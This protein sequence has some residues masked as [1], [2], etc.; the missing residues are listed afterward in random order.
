[1]KKTLVTL[2]IT[3]AL[4]IMVLSIVCCQPSTVHTTATT[5]HTTA[6]TISG[7]NSTAE[8]VIE[9]TM[10]WIYSTTHNKPHEVHDET[11]S[12][13]GLCQLWIYCVDK[14]TGKEIGWRVHLFEKGSEYYLTAPSISGYTPETYAL[15]GVIELYYSKITFYYYPDEKPSESNSS[16][17]TEPI[18]FTTY[19][20]T[21]K[22]DIS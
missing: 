8:A 5:V 11:V 13:N 2:A 9:D 6:T 4:I 17:I 19:E 22:A 15:S 18:V 16:Y 14:N 20:V 1:M 3:L 21:E 10:S 7:K 12:E